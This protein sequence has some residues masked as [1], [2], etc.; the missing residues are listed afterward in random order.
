MGDSIRWPIASWE[1][2]LNAAASP[3]QCLCEAWPSER[4]YPG[5]VEW[6]WSWIESSWCFIDR[7]MRSCGCVP[8]SR[9]SGAHK[10][11]PRATTNKVNHGDE[12]RWCGVF[13]RRRFTSVERESGRGSDRE[14]TQLFQGKTQ[15]S[16]KKYNTHHT[17]SI[18]T[19][20]FAEMN[21]HIQLRRGVTEV[22]G[23]GH[24]HTEVHT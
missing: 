1:S 23:V 19:Q 24:I 22:N 2:R 12:R 10:P 11:S 5:A 3:V 17:W 9:V 4:D 20:R 14:N 6:S 16:T 18:Y 21:T 7:A 13:A 8:C 15:I